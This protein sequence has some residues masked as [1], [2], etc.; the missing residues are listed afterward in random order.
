MKNQKLFSDMK[1]RLSYGVTGNQEIGLYQSLATLSGNN[2]AFGGQNVIGYATANAAPNPDLKWETTRQ[3][4]VGLDMGWLDNRISASIDAYKSSRRT[5]S[6]AWICRRSRA[7][8]RSCA[9]S[10]RCRT[11]VSSCSSTR[12]TSPENFGWRSSLSAAKN[13]N[14]V[15][16]LGVANQ[17]P[18]TGDKGIS[19]QTGGA[20]MVIK[21]G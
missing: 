9:T 10:A 7:T 11:P 5:C 12:S 20:V 8:R 15:L 4:N 21:V 16:A 14:K 13:S 1:V 19:G 2:Y 17:I 3:T 18:Y 6:S